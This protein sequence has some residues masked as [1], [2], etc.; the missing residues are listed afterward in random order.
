M[1]NESNMMVVSETTL[2][3]SFGTTV[4]ESALG[5][6]SDWYNPWPYQPIIEHYYPSCIGHWS[7][8]DTISR[9]FKIVQ[10]LIDKKVVK[11]ETIKDFI[12]LVNLI[13]KEL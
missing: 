10:K 4:S 12:E 3:S 13:A 1:I 6:F 8:E 9:A 5:W 11:A 2:D 7:S